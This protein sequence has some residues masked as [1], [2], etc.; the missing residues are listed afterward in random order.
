MAVK[1]TSMRMQEKL[2]T[3]RAIGY[4]IAIAVIIVL[5]LLRLIPRGH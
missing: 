4:T 5:V 3:V 1:E 2:G